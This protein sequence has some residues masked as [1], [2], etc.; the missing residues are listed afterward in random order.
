[1]SSVE[2]RRRDAFGSVLGVLVFLGGIFLLLLTFRL[3]YDMF[4]VP[5]ADALGLHGSK[6]MNVSVV[7]NSLTN[8]VVKIL[9]L[10]IMG[11]VS[12]LIANRG[13]LLYTHSRGLAVKV[14][15]V[16]ESDAG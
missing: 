8:I 9:L 15:K 4:T 14:R 16:E 5:P 2:H 1:V 12:S 7:G 13:I 11:V 6:E 3:A 10:L